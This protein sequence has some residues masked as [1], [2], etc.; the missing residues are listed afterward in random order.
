M[1]LLSYYICTLFVWITIIHIFGAVR[2]YVLFSGPVLAQ[3]SDCHTP[4]DY[5]LKYYDEEILEN[6]VYLSNLH[7]IQIQCCVPV[8]TIKEM[9]GFLGINLVMGYHKFPSWKMYWHS[10]ADLSV[11]FISSTM[12]R[13]RFSQILSNLYINH[14]YQMPKDNEDKVYKM[15]PLIEALNKTLCT[16]IQ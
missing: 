3:F 11:A 16:V 7:I 14:N 6:I 5:F 4:G 2:F 15:C 12:A 10:D 9:D 1:A 8:I 13:N